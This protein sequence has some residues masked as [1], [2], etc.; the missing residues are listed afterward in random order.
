MEMVAVSVA[1]AVGSNDDDDDDDDDR[2]SDRDRDLDEVVAVQGAEAR[3]HHV[4]V[5][6]GAHRHPLR[7]CV[8]RKTNEHRERE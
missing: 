8:E 2:D 5:V 3:V 7:H 4:H 6:L 1:V